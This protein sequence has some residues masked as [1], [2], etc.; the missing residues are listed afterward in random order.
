[1]NGLIGI[2]LGGTK[3]ELAVVGPAGQVIHRH[4]R[5]TPAG[6]YPATLQCV[7]DMVAHSVATLDMPPPVALGLAI[8]GCLDPQTGTVRGANSVVLNGQPMQADLERLLGC[9]VLMENDANCLAVSEAVD[10]P[11]TA[12]PGVARMRWPVSGDTTP[13][14]GWGRAMSPAATAG[15]A[16]TLAWKLGSVAPVLRP[17]MRPTRVSFASRQRSLRP[18]GAASPRP[19]PVG[20][21]TWT[22]WPVPWPR[23]STP[24][25]P[26]PSCLA[27]A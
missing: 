18:C 23:S 8:P 13:C 17:I 19:W 14:R 3:M 11:F 16:N 1:M 7:S 25:T 4:R 26:T 22:V 10:G 5:A 2:D 15:V 20:T 12:K 27:A 9:R 6:D 24:W 21:V